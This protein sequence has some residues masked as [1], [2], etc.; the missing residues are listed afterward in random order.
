MPATYKSALMVSPAAITVATTAGYTIRFEPNVKKLVPAIAVRECLR[1]GAKEV[2]R[3]KNT[4][5]ELPGV[6][7]LGEVKSNVYSE[8]ETNERDIEE[9]EISSVETSAAETEQ[10]NESVFTATENKVRTVIKLLVDEA[11]EENFTTAGVLKVG[12]INELVDGVTVTSKLRDATWDKMVNDGE[13]PDDW[14]DTLFVD[15]LNDDSEAA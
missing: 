11:N 3:V 14:P 9:V 6:G 4:E 10:K 1:Y 7:S 8:S 12:P 13:I 15:D 2:G 5:T